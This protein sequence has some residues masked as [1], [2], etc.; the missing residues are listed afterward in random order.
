MMV[1]LSWLPF[2]V[3]CNDTA[4]ATAVRES[5][6]LFPVIEVFHLLALAVLGGAVLS[7]DLRLLGL[8]VTAVPVSRL[9]AAVRPW[10]LSSLA[11]IFVSGGLLFLSE[12]LKCYENPA[13]RLKLA[14][15]SL[16]LLFAAF[17]RT[18]W[19]REGTAASPMGGRLVA[20]VSITLWTGVGIAGRGIGFW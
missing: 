8:G 14:F 1:A 19:T 2:F 9:A 15:L 11:I 17:V 5:A 12:A 3:W 7:V 18:R 16:A 4:V 6:W 13:F 10:L 20:L